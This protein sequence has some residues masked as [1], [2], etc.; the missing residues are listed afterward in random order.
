MGQWTSHPINP[1]TTTSDLYIHPMSLIMA[2][3]PGQ[4]HQVFTIDMPCIAGMYRRGLTEMFVV[5]LIFLFH[6]SQ[7]GVGIRSFATDAVPAINCWLACVM[8]EKRDAETLRWPLPQQ[9]VPCSIVVD[10]LSL[11]QLSHCQITT[12]CVFIYIRKGCFGDVSVNR[13]VWWQ[14]KRRLDGPCMFWHWP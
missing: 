1:A 7:L 6:V 11:S 12:I 10:N 5:L 8:S 13:C 2:Y 14:P 9:V 3:R 4:T